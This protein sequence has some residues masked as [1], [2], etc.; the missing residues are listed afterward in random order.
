MYTL[1][2]PFSLPPGRDISAD[3]VSKSAGP[4]ELSLK[5]DG[6]L[7]VLT[8][9]GLSSE[10]EAKIF[11][12][13]VRSGLA[14]LLLKDGIAADA[15]LEPQEV[16]Y[17]PDPKL[18]AANLS[19]NF[20][21][22]IESP[23]DG[24][25]DGAMPAVYPTEKAMRVIT[26]GQANLL[27]TTPSQKALDLLTEGVTF[28]RSKAFAEDLKLTV[29]LDLYGAYFT[30]LSANGRFL[31]LIMALEALA[32]GVPRTPLVLELL[33]RWSSEVK[34][35]MKRVPAESDDAKSLEA[36]SRELLFRREDSIRRQ[37]RNLVLLTLQAVPDV[38][39]EGLA[40]SA[41]KLYDL[42]SKLVHEGT[43]D[44]QQLGRA[45]SDAK[46][47]V[48]RVLMS[49]FQKLIGLP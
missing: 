35:L 36:V 21:V 9:S 28:P 1:R 40:S 44:R 3:K 29:A 42:R 25:I 38:D 2:F 43:L 13:K 32:V 17:T 11:I 7:Y 46:D 22:Q 23:V 16:F 20:G 4:F 31:T 24:L 41:T 34:E 8:V 47:I 26:G 10:E 45:T 15:V 49:R 27:V 37:I 5:K 12:A 30:E 18:A 6:R 39:A 33:A 19:K 48:H 14:W